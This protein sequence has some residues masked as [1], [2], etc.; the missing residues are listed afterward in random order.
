[1][2]GALGWGAV[3][4]L[5]AEEGRVAARPEAGCSGG[6]RSGVH[7]MA[8]RCIGRERRAGP[9]TWGSQAEYATGCVGVQ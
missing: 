9:E 8:W 2:R 1:M 3:G 6:V 4:G 7:G 5:A